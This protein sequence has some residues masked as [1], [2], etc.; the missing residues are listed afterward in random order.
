MKVFYGARIFD[1][2][3]LHDDCALVVEG[4][5]IQALTR[6]GDRPRGGDECDLG[7]GILSPGFIDWQINGGGGVLFNANPTVEVVAAII[8]SS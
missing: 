5:S 7:G 8:R 4:E 6:V 2:E 3:R 1:G